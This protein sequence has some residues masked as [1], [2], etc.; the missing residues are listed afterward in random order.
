[1]DK[2]FKDLLT[3][4]V[5]FIFEFAYPRT[6]DLPPS[7]EEKYEKQQPGGEM[8]AANV[9]T[10]T[11]RESLDE[12]NFRIY[13]DTLCPAMWSQDMRLDPQVRASL[14]QMAQDFY[15]KTGFKAPILDIYLMGSIAN[16]NW[17]VDSDADVH[18]IIDYNQLQMPPETATEVIKTAGA[19]WNAEHNATVKGHKVELNIQN[20]REVKPHVTGI[21]SLVK[22]AWIRVPQ[23]QQ[24]RFDTATIQA[25]YKDMKQYLESALNSG[26]RETMKQAKKYLDAFRQYGLDTAGEL[27]VEN[28]VFKI[29]RSKGLI[30]AL[31]DAIT[32][33]YDKEMSV[34]E[35]GT[36]DLKQRLPQTPEQYR[37]SDDGKLKLD[38][39]TLDNLMALRAKAARGIAY[40]KSGKGGETFGASLKHEEEELK[41]INQEIK[42]R[43]EYINKPVA[44]EGYGAGDP[45]KDPKA[46][47]R[48]TVDFESSSK[49]LKEIALNDPHDIWNQAVRSAA[50]Q[51]MPSLSDPIEAKRMF[52]T[53]FMEIAK[54]SKAFIK[55]IIQQD[56]ESAS[57]AANFI[58]DVNHR[59]IPL[60]QHWTQTLID[61]NPGK[62][63]QIIRQYQDVIGHLEQTNAQLSTIY[64][65]I[66]DPD[67]F[68]LVSNQM[69]HLGEIFKNLMDSVDNLI[70]VRETL[71]ESPEM[72]TLKK[73]KRPLTDEERQLV[74]DRDATWHH[75]PNGEKTPAVWKSVVNGKTWYVCNTHR[76]MQVKPTL[77]GAI[78]AFDFIKTTA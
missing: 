43:I 16:Y 27:S 1:M 67:T 21:Y 37:Y 9:T 54:A 63:S 61:E 59:M 33:T 77:K 48:W 22:D 31:K 34:K 25:V 4:T 44:K 24:R 55:A 64:T 70:D 68:P 42:R 28:I 56:G 52:R 6:D 66:I 18:V 40:L 78:R 74:M 46:R 26:D 47:G 76:A 71:M 49:I 3:K 41:R 10:A 19:K 20:V 7:G 15:E 13:N 12:A 32:A 51:Q 73:N 53:N 5:D 58:G 50:M 2:E 72:K 75:G 62:K 57:R 29:I 17:T 38:M 36:K 30:K 60:L 8:M 69:K 14:L 39:M 35:V 45:S 11:W 65:S 23:H